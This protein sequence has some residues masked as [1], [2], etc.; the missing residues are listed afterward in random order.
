MR[1]GV[2]GCLAL[3]ALLALGLPV[4][5]GEPE[6]RVAFRYVWV[7]NA[8]SA[9]TVPLLRLTINAVVP[10][11]EAHLSASIPKGVQMSVRAAG[12]APTP[13]AD[14]GLT[15]GSLAAGQTVVVDLEVARPA[16]GGGLIEFQLDAVRDGQTVHEGV[17]VVVGQPGITPK[18][19]NGAAEFPA[20]QQ[21]PTP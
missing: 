20:A 16:S 8:D 21:D 1:K 4:A 6:G 11:G 3:V 7:D 5:A 17:G 14:E 18:L 19:R 10:L 9:S 2:G 15:L 12:R 13:W